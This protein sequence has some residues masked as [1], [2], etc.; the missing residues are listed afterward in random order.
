MQ[1]V[2]DKSNRKLAVNPRRR[3]YQ[4]S[5]AMYEGLEWVLTSLI[6]LGTMMVSYELFSTKLPRYFLVVVV[7]CTN[8]AAL[9]TRNTRISFSVVTNRRRS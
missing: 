8:A 4:E 6:G 2:K 7:F 9:S 1:R 3:P 5:E